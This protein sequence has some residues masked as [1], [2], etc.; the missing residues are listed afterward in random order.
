MRPRRVDR[1]VAAARGSFVP[2]GRPEGTTR[3]ADPDI[4]TFA[5][6]PEFLGLRLYPLQLL[7]LKVIFL[8]VELLTERDVEELAR[9]MNGFALPDDEKAPLRYEGRHG[10]QPDLLDRMRRCRDDGR[11][12]FREV[13]AVIG[14]RGSKGL[15]CSISVA[16]VLYRCLT[17][18][19]MH[20]KFGI[21]P[22][23]RLS[24][25][26][27]AATKRQAMDNQFRDIVELIR[28]APCFEPYRC[29]PTSDRLL[30][31]THEQIAD[32]RRP[33]TRDAAY[34]V[35]AAESTPN[36]VRGRAC[37]AIVMDEA[38]HI[39]ATGA[40]RSAEELAKAAKPALATFGNRSFVWLGSSPWQMTG[41]LHDDFLCGLEVHA[42]THVAVHYDVAVFQLASWMPY[43]GYEL[44]QS[45]DLPMSPGGAFYPPIERAL[46]AANDEQL[47]RARTANPES[48]EVEFGAQWAAATDAYLLLDDIEPMFGP[49]NGEL[50]RMQSS[51]A[52]LNVAYYAHADPAVTNDRYAFVI[53]HLDRDR[54]IGDPHVIF[55]LIHTWS[56]AEFPLGRIDY[57][58]VEDALCAI[59]DQFPM[60][61]ELTFDQHNSEHT[62]QMLAKHVGRANR[63]VRT[64]VFVR[65]ETHATNWEDFELF[66]K[67]LL[68]RRLHAP[69]H[70]LARDELLFLRRRGDRV[71][72]QSTGP[73]QSK[74]IVDAMVAVTA[75]ILGPDPTIH[76][77]LAESELH[78][79]IPGGLPVRGPNYTVDSLPDDHPLV[80]Q[81]RRT[82]AVPR[83]TPGAPRGRFRRPER[84]W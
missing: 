48:F 65:P 8:A 60:L 33:D 68:M 79:A 13:V 45:G 5:T 72:H 12:W 59:V 19:D 36:A 30:L 29:A 26:V 51:G 57:D 3:P 44:T 75:R 7:I 58:E 49:Y 78:G 15:L 22:R 74:D 50:L 31:F 20:A 28:S 52:G 34:E 53:A 54:E 23:K 11:L 67:M 71:D 70:S 37:I 24:V 84:G 16:Y 25:T 66:K 73:V 64:D 61:V 62:A 76:Q 55:D 40:N 2:P 43:E 6:S 83:F 21:D 10:T 38:A 32:G 1:A 17:Q 39:V 46:L 56:A 81:L 35:V 9:W 14:R 18:E 82:M 4:V 77:Q 41:E 69:Q 63:P 80:Q 27:F 47:M 42:D